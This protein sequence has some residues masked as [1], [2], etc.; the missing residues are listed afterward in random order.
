VFSLRTHTLKGLI[1]KCARYC[2]CLGVDGFADK[3]HWEFRCGVHSGS[4][5]SHS[6]WLHLRRFAF[7]FEVRAKETRAIFAS[8]VPSDLSKTI[9][10]EASGLEAGHNYLTESTE[11]FGMA[12]SQI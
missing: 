3:S 6:H 2:G 8:C 10:G 11:G 4:G 5:N 1:Q 9:S 12:V 7:V